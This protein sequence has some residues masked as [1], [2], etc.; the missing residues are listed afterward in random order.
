MALHAV[1]AADRVE[2]LTILTDRLSE[3]LGVELACFEARRP[4]D[5]AAGIEETGRLA[6]L[7]RHESTR[8]KANPALIAEAPMEAR[9]RLRRSTEIFETILARHGRAVEAARII[10]EGIVRAI[11]GEIAN[12]RGHVAGYGADA[13]SSGGGASALTLNRRA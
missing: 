8:V 1:D 4:Q 2:Q 6:N 11:A 5:A 12:Q 13:R 3:R 9:Q 10:T 7:Y